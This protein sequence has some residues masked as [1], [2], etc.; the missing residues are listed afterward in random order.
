MIQQKKGMPFVISL[1][2]S[3]QNAT[4]YRSIEV[5]DKYTKQFNSFAL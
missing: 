3:T 4:V 1:T 5:V 2:K